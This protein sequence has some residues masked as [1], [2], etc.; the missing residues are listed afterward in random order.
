MFTCF[1]VTYTHY[2]SHAVCLNIPV[3]PL[4]LKCSFFAPVSLR[5]PPEKAQSALVGLREKYGAP[6][7]R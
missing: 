2:L 7:Q 1:N 5:P 3:F 6:L 4:C